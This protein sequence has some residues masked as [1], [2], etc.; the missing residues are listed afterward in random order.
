MYTFINLLKRHRN[1]QIRLFK[2]IFLPLSSPKLILKARLG[3]CFVHNLSRNQNSIPTD[4][5]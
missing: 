1:D 2:E 3:T 5:F 4:D